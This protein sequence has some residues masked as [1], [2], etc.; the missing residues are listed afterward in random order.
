MLRRLALI[1]SALTGAPL[2]AAWLISQN[3]L[4]P[5]PRVEDH[6]LDDFDLAAQPVAFPSRD[7]TRLAGW[8]IP[9]VSGEPAPGIVLSHGWARS[10][11]ELL[12]HANFLHRAGF[13][14]LLFDQRNRGESGGEMVT[15]G[16]REPDDLL[17]ALDVIAARPEVDAGRIGLF[18]MSLG[19]VVSVLAGA[20]DE[21]VRTIVAE[22]PFATHES[23]M[24]RALRH[25]YRLPSFPVAHLAKWM[26]GRRVG[27]PLEVAEPLPVVRSFSPRPLFVIACDRD[28]VIGW[29]ET[30]RLH[31]GAGEPKQ[32]WLIPG[33][34][35][36]RGWQAARDEYE[37]RVVEF[38]RRA[39]L[40]EMPARSAVSAEPPA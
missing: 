39:L 18:G 12:P 14:V 19:G 27:L 31:Q 34:D 6:T 17:G 3:V 30:Q 38:F 16:L 4:H 29:Q 33:A 8:F 5:K 24:T 7:G 40:A 25:Y 10:R 32:W 9:A 21:R 26:I 2:A 28:A 15:M 37:Q 23:I 35:H 36:A 20:R 22:C 11:A 1:A 13:A